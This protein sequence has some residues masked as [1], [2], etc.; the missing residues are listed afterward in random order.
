M[1]RIML[2]AALVAI[3]GFEVYSGE[4]VAARIGHTNGSQTDGPAIADIG[5]PTGIGQ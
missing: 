4:F 1:R 3:L 5:W 2:G